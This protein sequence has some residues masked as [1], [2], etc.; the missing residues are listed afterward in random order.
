VVRGW[1][2]WIMRLDP[3]GPARN[4]LNKLTSEAYGVHFVSGSRISRAGTL[5]ARDQGRSDELQDRL[6]SRK[7]P[8]GRILSRPKIRLGR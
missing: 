8:A 5:V 4:L 2:Q 7:I 6:G 1:C 3:Q